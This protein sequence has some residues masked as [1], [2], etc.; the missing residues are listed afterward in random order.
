MSDSLE[1]LNRKIAGAGDIGGVVRTMKAMAASN[2]VQYETAVSS[3]K[4]Y[5]YN[6]ALG[7]KALFNQPGSN[8]ISPQKKAGPKKKIY[9][10]IFGSDLGL[11]GQFN[12]RITGFALEFLNKLHGEKEIWAVGEHIATRL[13]DKGLVTSALFGVP[14]SVNSIGP[15]VK[16]ILAKTEEG[17]IE[18]EF[19]I[20]HNRPKSGS[21]YE[22]V[23]QRWLPLDT[24]W[25]K[26]IKDLKWP[27]G[28]LPEVIGDTT[29]TLTTL[30]KEYLFVSLFR[31]CAESLSSEN[32][33]RL[34]AMQRA[35]KNIDEMLLDLGSKYHRLRQSS[36]D[37]ELFDVISGFE[38]LK[39]GFVV[40]TSTTIAQLLTIM[41]TVISCS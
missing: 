29:A 27:S 20:F 25:N 33:S 3:L 15:L 6:I 22:P 36:I 17:K 23:F 40:S 30:I 10:L 8:T 26:D 12:D 4:E 16:Q 37:E 34:E 5:D 9:A 31:S 7:I 32:A 39:G 2:I 21:G 28:N 1:S 35:E 41:F 11:V 13:Q 14:V 19:Y 18:K 24:A 38:A